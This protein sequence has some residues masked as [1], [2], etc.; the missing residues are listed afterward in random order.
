[1]TVYV[2]SFLTM[3]NARKRT[4]TTTTPS[5]NGLVTEPN[6]ST[7][8]TDLIPRRY[9]LF[10]RKF[11]SFPEAESRSRSRTHRLRLR[12]G[13]SSFWSPPP[14]P[15]LPDCE[16]GYRDYLPTNLDLEDE[17]GHLETQNERS[18]SDESETI[19]GTIRGHVSP[20]SPLSP[21]SVDH[22]VQL[23]LQRPPSAYDRSQMVSEPLSLL[24]PTPVL[25]IV[26]RAHQSL[27]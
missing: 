22:L 5:T 13:T 14:P 24:S 26:C 16:Q 8:V 17:R 15:T 27:T 18:L 21:A 7:P 19:R 10:G 23:P 25:M 6:F 3:L 1:M 4:V 9:Q 11:H 12:S 2:A 20:T